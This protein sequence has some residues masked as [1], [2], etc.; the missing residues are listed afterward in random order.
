MHLNK[1]V[2]VSMIKKLNRICQRFTIFSP[3][4]VLHCYHMPMY[5]CTHGH[6]VR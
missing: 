4:Q 5:G 6:Y 3:E 1:R 2:I